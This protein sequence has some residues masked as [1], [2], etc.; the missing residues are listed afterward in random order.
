MLIRLK[1]LQRFKLPL[2]IHPKMITSRCL[3]GFFSGSILLVSGEVLKAL[4]PPNMPLENHA[5][6]LI[7]SSLGF[8]RLDHRAG[9]F[10]SSVLE[11]SWPS[12]HRTKP[13]LLP[14][15]RSYDAD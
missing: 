12:S 2:L 14:V 13:F 8:L 9:Q 5:F 11:L 4:L 15:K 3:E 6:I 7:S 1:R 10:F